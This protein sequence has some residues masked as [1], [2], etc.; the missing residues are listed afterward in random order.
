M[1]RLEG[2]KKALLVR[3]GSTEGTDDYEIK[4]YSDNIV[5]T[6]T[7]QKETGES[8]KSKPN[9]ELT[10][11][12]KYTSLN[13]FLAKAEAA[14]DLGTDNNGNNGNDLPKAIRLNGENA[15]SAPDYSVAIGKGS[16]ADGEHNFAIGYGNIIKGHDNIGIGTRNY[17]EDGFYNCILGTDNRIDGESSN[18]TITGKG[19]Q[20][21][22]SD[23][24]KIIY[25]NITRTVTEKNIMNYLRVIEGQEFVIAILIHDNYWK[26][27]WFQEG[28]WSITYSTDDGQEITIANDS[29]KILDIHENDPNAHGVIYI[30]ITFAEA[31][32]P[33]SISSNIEKFKMTFIQ[34]EAQYVQPLPTHKYINGYHNNIVQNKYFSSELSYPRRISYK[35]TETQRGYVF[36]GLSSDQMTYLRKYIGTTSSLW[37]P[38]GKAIPLRLKYDD[39]LH[40]F[41]IENYENIKSIFPSSGYIEGLDKWP[42]KDFPRPTNYNTTILGQYNNPDSDDIFQIGCGTSNNDRKNALSVNK[43]GIVKIGEENYLTSSGSTTNLSTDVDQPSVITT[44]ELTKGIWIISANIAFNAVSAAENEHRYLSLSITTNTERWNVQQV[45]TSPFS[46]LSTTTIKYFNKDTTVYLEGASSN[47]PMTGKDGWQAAGTIIAARIG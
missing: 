27:G 6:S 11:N 25:R 45:H 47:P 30:D 14:Y 15:N 13:D 21:K 31:G 41:V 1:S 8:G 43:D 22:G 2:E 42:F 32:A 10:K 17:I 33:S 20:L 12:E 39:T 37:S 24:S 38:Y 18:N 3:D 36:G 46:V 4:T 9:S 19:N 5:L 29:S 35:I 34:R 26:T 7:T 28:N 23:E 16:K 40:A 44:L